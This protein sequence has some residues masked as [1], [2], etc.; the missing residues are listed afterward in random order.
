MHMHMHTV[1]D[2]L[3]SRHMQLALPSGLGTIAPV[4]WPIQIPMALRW[5]LTSDTIACAY[6]IAHATHNRHMIAPR[7]HAADHN[8]HERGAT[9]VRKMAQNVRRAAHAYR[10]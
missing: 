4:L 5:G 3:G 8:G 6:E 7:L 2:L 10:S 9:D 1:H